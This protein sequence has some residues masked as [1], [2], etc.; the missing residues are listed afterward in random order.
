MGRSSK[1][2]VDVSKWK[3]RGLGLEDDYRNSKTRNLPCKPI[4]F[5]KRLRKAIIEVSYVKIIQKCS[6]VKSI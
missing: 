6:E 3:R 1:A 5:K 4:T 2:Q